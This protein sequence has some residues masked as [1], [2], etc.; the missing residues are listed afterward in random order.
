MTPRFVVLEN[1]QTVVSS[2]EIGKM[3]VRRVK[4]SVFGQFKFELPLRYL[5]R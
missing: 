2:T 1:E 4:N 3:G 5:S